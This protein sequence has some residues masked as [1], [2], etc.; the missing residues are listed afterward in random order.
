MGRVIKFTSP[1]RHD[2]QS[3][4]EISPEAISEDARDCVR[5]AKEHLLKAADAL[6]DGTP[7]F[8]RLAWMI[9]DMCWMLEFDVV[10]NNDQLP[11]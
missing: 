3:V 5:D 7:R 2:G 1:H 10:A 8:E 11:S 4:T 6:C 9:Q